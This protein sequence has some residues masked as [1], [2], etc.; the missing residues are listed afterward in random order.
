MIAQ[1][2][3]YYE[4]GEKRVI[5]SDASW[6]IT[7]EGP[8]GTNNEFDGEEYDA[9]KEMPGWNTYPFDDTKWLQ[10]EVVSLPGGK[11][12]AQLNRNMKVMDTVKPIGITESAPGVYILDMGQNMVGWLRMKVKGQS[13]DTLKLRFAELL[14]KDGSIYTANLRTAHSADTYIL[15]GN[16]MEEWQPT[17]TYH[18]FRFVELTG[19]REKPSLSDFEGQVIYDEMETTGNLET[20]DPM[21]NRIYKNAYWGIR[22]NYRGMPTDCPQRDERMG[23]L[24]DRA[25]GSQGE[26][27]NF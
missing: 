24:G 8:I 13:G 26:S 25:V 3:V 20:S 14:Q 2:E 12:E 18:G 5:A 6:K 9:R 16:S 21:I 22:G 7:A 17:F 19:F 15:K 27:Y 23:W 11:L 1:L 10:A 4:D